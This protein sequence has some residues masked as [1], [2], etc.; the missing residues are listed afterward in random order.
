MDFINF[1]YSA[2]LGGLIDELKISPTILANNN[3]ADERYS[4]TQTSTACALQQGA[5]HGRTIKFL[6]GK[7]A[8][9]KILS[10]RR[11]CETHAHTGIVMEQWNNDAFQ[12][13]DLK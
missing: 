5:M 4:S 7:I 10:V 8:L 13:A 12:I 1:A 2:K 11:P 3:S 9:P 6:Q